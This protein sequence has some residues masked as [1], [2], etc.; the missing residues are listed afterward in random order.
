[1]ILRAQQFTDQFLL[2]HEF[3]KRLHRRFQAEG[4]R[5]PFPISTV[6]IEESTEWWRSAVGAGRSGGR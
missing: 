1:V 5:I 3:V 6:Q 4:I 2:K